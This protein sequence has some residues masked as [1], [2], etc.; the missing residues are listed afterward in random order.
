M[1]YGN[2]VEN[3]QSDKSNI[4]QMHICQD[5]ITYISNNE[6]RKRFKNEMEEKDKN[7]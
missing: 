2:R 6:I 7:I 3:N 1:R 4:N 5:Y